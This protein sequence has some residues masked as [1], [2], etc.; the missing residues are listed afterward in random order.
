MD[1]VVLNIQKSIRDNGGAIDWPAYMSH[2]PEREKAR[3]YQHTKL[4]ESQNLIKRQVVFENGVT[5]FT[6]VIPPGEGSN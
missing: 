4:W 5:A 2:F 6:V 3:A 1:E